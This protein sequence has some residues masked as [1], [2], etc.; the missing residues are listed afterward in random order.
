MVKVGRDDHLRK[1]EKC[2]QISQLQL[3][4]PDEDTNSAIVPG[5]RMKVAHWS[6]LSGTHCFCYFWP[7]SFT[8]HQCLLGFTHTHSTHSLA[9]S[10]WLLFAEPPKFCPNQ[11]WR[12]LQSSSFLMQTHLAA[13]SINTKIFHCLDYTVRMTNTSSSKKGE[14]QKYLCAYLFKQGLAIILLGGLAG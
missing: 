7:W 1:L 3:R 12:V 10:D 14:N 13:L 11:S 2:K 4:L 8:W 5:Y 6:V 9:P